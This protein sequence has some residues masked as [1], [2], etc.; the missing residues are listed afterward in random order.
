MKYVIFG[1]GGFE[2]AVL[3]PPTMSHKDITRGVGRLFRLGNALL[4]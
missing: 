2:E 4:A 3:L 1:Y